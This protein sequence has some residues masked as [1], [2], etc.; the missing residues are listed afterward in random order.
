MRAGE[1]GSVQFKIM[2]SSVVDWPHD[3][4]IE[5]DCSDFNTNQKSFKINIK[6][7][8]IAHLRMSISVPAFCDDQ[9]KTITFFPMT[10]GKGNV[11]GQPFIVE[12]DIVG[13]K[14]EYLHYSREEEKEP[15]SVGAVKSL[16]THIAYGL[17]NVHTS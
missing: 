12:L 13:K 16:Q 10:Q 5:N 17:A 14:L 4:T 1:T 7:R 3:S 8:T 6:K 11:F 9:K 15:A 2:N